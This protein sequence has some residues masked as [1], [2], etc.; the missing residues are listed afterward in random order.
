MLLVKVDSLNNQYIECERTGARAFFRNEDNVF[1]FTGYSGSR[2]SVL[3][4]FFLAHFKVVKGFYRDMTIEDPLPVDLFHSRFL[5][6]FQDLVAPFFIFINSTYK[7]SYT[8]IQDQLSSPAIT[9]N[10]GCTARMFRS[11]SGKIDF[12][13]RMDEEGIREFRVIRKNRVMEV[14]CI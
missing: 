7:L 2:R 1:Y 10:A 6:F 3:Y 14:K 5:L 11:S 4:Y 13:T 8:R 9:L 12:E